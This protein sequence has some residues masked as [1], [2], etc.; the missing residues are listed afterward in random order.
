MN[1]A[2]V[3][4]DDMNAVEKSWRMG[5]RSEWKR[6]EKEKYDRSQQSCFIQLFPNFLESMK[7]QTFLAQN[8]FDLRSS[9]ILH[10]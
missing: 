4:G 1:G 2:V 3:V 5:K 6:L 7:Y 8:L 10:H 9:D